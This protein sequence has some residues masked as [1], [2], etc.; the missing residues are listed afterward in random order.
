M[1]FSFQMQ[2]NK[3]VFFVFIALLLLLPTTEA[4]SSDKSKSL[5]QK[6]YS[7]LTKG[8][9]ESA[10]K[11]FEL[12]FKADPNDG[13]AL[14]FQGVALNRLG[15]FELSAPKL[16]R[17]GLKKG[18]HPDWNFER[19][20][21]YLGLG[22]WKK[23]VSLLEVFEKEHPGRGQTLEFIGRAYFGL[24]NYSKAESYLKKAAKKDPNLKKTTE[25]YLSRISGT[26]QAPSATEGPKSEKGKNWKIYSNI[27]GNYNTN[28]INLGNGVTRPADISRQESPFAS[29]TLGG[30]YRF[31]L[32]DSSQFS[33]GNQILANLYEVSGRL[34]FLD[35]YSFLQFRHSFDPTKI[36]GITFSNDFSIIQ[37]AKFR[38][39][40]GIKPLFGWKLADWLVSEIGY[41][42][43]WADYFF[44]S[45]ANQNR[46]S[47]S[48]T[49]LMNNIFSVPE[50]KLRFRLGYFHLWNRATGSDFD[51]GGNTL[52]FG[53][54]HSFY[55]D[56]MGEL[57]FSQ[58]WNR[59]SKINSLTTGTKRSDDISNVSVQFKVPFIGPIKGFLHANYTRNKS[60]IAVFNYRAWQ[61]GGGLSA[62]F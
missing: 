26:R 28:A 14:F 13:T 21:S 50:T 58:A 11:Q 20:W 57:L 3:K 43:G 7:F 32:S 62:E 4:V 53:V 19:G 15:K 41:N 60:N 46:D 35:N 51:Y 59:Y 42:F 54:S 16:D 25:I 6:G 17:A 40:I 22:E 9:F 33:L 2:K 23:A 24:K 47:Y 18:V 8:N 52:I 55:E 36:L 48:H 27:G 31:D 5:V 37:T 30:S 1:V 12:A 29:G 45:N 10:L 44:P 39:Q 49:V 38:D 34:H 61:G 56:V